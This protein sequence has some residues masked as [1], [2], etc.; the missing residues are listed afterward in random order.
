[1]AAKIKK[2]DTVVVL[3]GRDK[4]RS[5]E[6]IQ[7]LPKDDKAFVRGINLVKKH[8]KQTQNQEGGIIS[9]EAA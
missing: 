7:V 4:G 1:M 3:T 5:G 6:V 2:G 8:Q 9:K